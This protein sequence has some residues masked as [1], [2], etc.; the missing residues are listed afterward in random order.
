MHGAAI[1]NDP[2]TKAF[3][4]SSGSTRRSPSTV[5]PAYHSTKDD[6]RKSIFS[7][8]FPIRLSHISKPVA[9]D[10]EQKYESRS[11]PVIP[12]IQRPPTAQHPYH[13]GDADAPY[14]RSSIYSQATNL[15]RF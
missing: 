7:R 9:H 13:I 15:T 11:S 6:R 4:M 3:S 5:L 1:P 12:D 10:E 14:T 8:K 2:S